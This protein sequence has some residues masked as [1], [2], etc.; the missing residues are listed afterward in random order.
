MGDNKGRQTV[1]QYR[2]ALPVSAQRLFALVQSSSSMIRTDQVI[3]TTHQ[4][5][6]N[7][8]ADCATYVKQKWRLTVSACSVLI[9]G[10]MLM[11]ECF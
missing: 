10:R 7:T 11:A 9:G 8:L 5:R 4:S 2:G 3:R 1:Q 6:P